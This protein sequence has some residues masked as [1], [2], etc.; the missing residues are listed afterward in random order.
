MYGAYS[1]GVLSGWTE[2]GARPEFDVVTG[3]STGSLIGLAAFLGPKYDG[4]AREFYTDTKVSDIYTTRAWI[5]VP[6]SDSIASSKPLKKLVDGVVTDDVLAAIAKEH[7][8]GRRFYV[9]T[10]HL[11]SRK[12][13]VWDMGAIAH[14]KDLR[15]FRDVILASCSVPG[16]L[17]PVRITQEANGQTASELHVDGG[18]A[19]ALFVPQGLLAPVKG[20][21]SG[22]NVYVIVAG[23][24]FADP[25]AVRNRVLPV[26]GTS[27]TSL[28]YS[29]A[30]AEIAI[31]HHLTKLAGANFHLSAVPASDRADP[32]GLAFDPREMT[33]LYELGYVSGVAGP[34]WMTTPPFESSATDA[35]RE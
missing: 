9:G 34:E 8:T 17:S 12:F 35:I 16:M 14:R 28:L 32:D 18:T 20:G 2:T 13:V 24:L 6:W 7:R 22:T 15:K 4:I 30:R 3:V 31:I 29:S 19:A 21:P 1:A 11:E 5:Q 25:G 33:R 27:M 10:T 23:K 26:M